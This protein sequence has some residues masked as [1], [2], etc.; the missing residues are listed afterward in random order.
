VRLI[1]DDETTCRRAL[2]DAGLRVH[3]NQVLTVV[4]PN[5]PGALATTARALADAEVNV[6]AMYVLRHGGDQVEVA[7]AV[8]DRD[9]AIPLLPVKGTMR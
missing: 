5:R 2:A 7:I 1:A 6:E 3:E 4:L 9:A 8:D